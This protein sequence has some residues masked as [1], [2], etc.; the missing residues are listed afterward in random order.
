MC[1][2]TN[3]TLDSWCLAAPRN[4]EGLHAVHLG[5]RHTAVKHWHARETLLQCMLSK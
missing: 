2:A 3:P 1:M 4:P 5:H